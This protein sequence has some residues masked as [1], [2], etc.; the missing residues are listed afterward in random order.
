MNALAN[1]SFDLPAR[2]RR[3][4]RPPPPGTRARRRP[5]RR[6]TARPRRRSKPAARSLA[7]YSV[8]SSA[9][10]MQPTHSSML[11]RMSAGTSPRTT[12]SETAKRPPGFSTRNASR[13]TASLSPD[14]LITQFEMIDVDRVVGQRDRLDRALQELDVGRAGLAL[15]VARER[16]HL[17]GHVEP[18]GLAG[19]PDALRRQQH[20]DAAA[21]ARGRA[22]S[23]PARARAARSG[24]RSR[25]TPTPRRPG[26]RR[27]PRRNRGST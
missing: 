2:A 8:S 18:V 16:Q 1:L 21:R 19:R 13:S 3:R 25:A 15:V 10:A 20:V 4:P 26:G 9:P 11:R 24:C 17:V 7:A 6:A 14:R 27:A 12:T 22:R 5:C 23:G